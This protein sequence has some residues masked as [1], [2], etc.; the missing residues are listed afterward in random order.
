MK[1]S[2]VKEKKVR[3]KN[4]E[5]RTEKEREKNI[6]GRPERLKQYRRKIERDEGRHLSET[7][8]DERKKE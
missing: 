7:T 3:N 8:E 2:T 4:C 1:R 6:T 5:C